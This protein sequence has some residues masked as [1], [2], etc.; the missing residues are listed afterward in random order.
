MYN[1]LL[2][3]NKLTKKYPLILEGEKIRYA[4]LKEPNPTISNC[5]A[6]AQFLPEEFDLK[7]FIDYDRQFE[8]NFLSPLTAILDVIGWEAEKVS[9]LEAFFG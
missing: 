5:I 2:Q 7:P 8:K 9:N 1:H 4:Y 3:E 6:V